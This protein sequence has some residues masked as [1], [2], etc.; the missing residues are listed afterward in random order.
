MKQYLDAV[1]EVLSKGTRKENRTGVDTLSTF[2][3]NYEID[4]RQGFP[5]LTTKEI[6]WKNIVVENLWFL[7]GRTDIAFLKKHNCKFWDAWADDKGDVPSAYGN[8]WRAFPTHFDRV[9]LHTGDVYEVDASYNDQ[10]AWVIDELKRNPMSRRLVVS[11]WAPG[12]AQTSKLPPC[13]LMFVFNVQNDR[14]GER[15]LCLHFTQRSADMALGVPYNIAGYGF[16]LEL[17]ARFTG[18]KPGIIA[19]TL[20]DAHVYT[21]KPD[22]SMAEFDHVPG[23]QMQ[24]GRRPRFLPKLKI[25]AAIDSLADIEWLLELDTPE[26]MKNFVLEG[27]DPEPAIPFKVAV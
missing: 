20:I 26:L 13:H 22:G 17:I 25:G 14:H 23:L 3:I 4:M 27:Y 8:F 7:S 12:N 21:S 15:S 5:L 9:S 10:I 2:N 1:A 18:L 6:S 16:L 24:L 11:A 19:H